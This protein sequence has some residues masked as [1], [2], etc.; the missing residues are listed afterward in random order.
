[1]TKPLCI[2]QIVY[3]FIGWTLLTLDG[4]LVMLADCNRYA[5]KFHRTF[6][7]VQPGDRGRFIWSFA[8]QWRMSAEIER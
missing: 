1:M 3:T 8:G 2:G 5:M 7:D 6:G 4:Q